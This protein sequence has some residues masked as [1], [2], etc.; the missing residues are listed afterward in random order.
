MDRNII[1]LKT[2]LLGFVCL[3]AVILSGIALLAMQSRVSDYRAAAL[4]RAVMVRAQGVALDL[5]RTLE[6]DWS[7]LIAVA[8]QVEPQN[9]DA[10]GVAVDTL[11]GDRQRISWAG[12]AGLD[13]RVAAASGDMLL[14]ADI[15]ERLWY[16]RGLQ[17]DFAGD[18]RNAI[19]LNQLL[20]G[21]EEEPIRFLDLSTPVRN[22]EGDVQGVLALHLNFNWTSAFLAETAATLGIDLFLVSQDGTVIFASDGSVPAQLDLPSMR[23]A[24]VGVQVSG[25]EVW[26]DGET[27]LTSVI[28]QVVYGDLPSFGWRLVARIDQQALASPDTTLDEAIFALLAAGAVIL[29]VMTLV[30]YRMFLAPFQRLAREATQIVEGEMVFPSENHTTREAALLATALVR[31]Q[32]GD[33]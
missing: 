26:P 10:M 6:Q 29:L 25:T 18:A 30:F 15:T 28:P 27:Y 21:T 31:L 11:A 1:S 14:D 13:G 19:L 33:G 3:G 4:E 9:L 32:D 12:Y 22:A 17:G 5:S 24:R 2:A 16:Q 23:A 20:G 7:A 8:G